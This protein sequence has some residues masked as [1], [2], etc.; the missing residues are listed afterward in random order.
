MATITREQIAPLHERLHV[1]VSP[2]DYHPAFETALKKYAK[3]ANIPGFRKG[4]VPTGVVKKMYGAAFFTEEVLHSIEK[5]LMQYLQQENISYLAQPIPEET[6]DAAQILHTE[7]KDYT[8]S[9]EIGLKPSFSVPDLSK[10]STTLNIVDVT[11]EMIQENVER[12]RQRLGKK[13]QPETISQQED[14]LNVTFQKSDANGIVEESAEIKEHSLLLKNFSAAAQNQLIGKKKDEELV[15]QIGQAFED[16]ERAGLGKK[17][18]LVSDNIEAMQQHYVMRITKISFV[19]KRILDEAFFNEAIPGK[20]IKTEEAFRAALKSQMEHYW[21]H[22]AQHLLE[23]EIFHLLSEEVPM[24]FPES[25][26]KK[27]LS[28]NRENEQTEAS[29]EKDFPAFLNQLRWTLMSNEIATQQSLQVSRDEITDNLR[30]QISGY[31]GSMSLG[32]NHD[33]LDSYVE[34]MMDD[35]QQVENAYQRVFSSKV[36][37]WAASQVMPAEKKVSV[38]E[39]QKLQGKHQH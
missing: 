20:E 2:A 36:L 23:H 26:L 37:A 24:D 22:Q 19:E 28:K 34:R 39:F 27:W 4:M 33:W 10:L 21:K 3:N 31:F 5:E 6:N 29:I 7:P 38:E 32:G 30:Q 18:G 25:F 11:D 17:L 15:V 12:M 1:T 14:I 9:F 13:T 35:Q 16:K 8:F